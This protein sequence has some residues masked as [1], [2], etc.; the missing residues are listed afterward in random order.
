M[1]KA[2]TLLEFIVVISLLILIT[3]FSNLKIEEN[4]L[5][6]LTNRLVLYLKQTRYQSLIDD[7][8]SKNSNLW[9]K[10]RWTLKFLRCRENVGGIYYVIYSDKNQTGHAGFD[11]SLNDPLSNKKIYSSNRCEENSKNSKYVLI[12]KIFDIDEVNISCNKTAS[13]GQISFGNDG[14][15]YSK[16]SSYDNENFEYEIENKCIISLKSYKQGSREIVI[17]PKTGYIYKKDESL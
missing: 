15:V 7:K 6:N 3:T 14:R 13:L 17:E 9:H 11:E 4:N 5:E 16:L 8:N 1:K 2:F 10:E 12:T